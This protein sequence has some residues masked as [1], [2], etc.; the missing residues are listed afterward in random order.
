MKNFLRIALVI[1]V[2]LCVAIA[3]VACTGD[4]TTTTT[5]GKTTT[6]APSTSTAATTTPAATTTAAPT[7]TTAVV[8]TT[9]EVTTTEAPGLFLT[10]SLTIDGKEVT[11]V[12]FFESWGTWG[13]TEDGEITSTLGPA[14]GELVGV[15]FRKG[16]IEVRM[17][18]NEDATTTKTGDSGF[19][20]ALSDPFD[21]D[22][23]YYFEG[24]A[25]Y[26]F[27]LVSD[28]QGF[29]VSRVYY[30]GGAWHW[31]PNSNNQGIVAGPF[32][33]DGKDVTI[34]IDTDGETYIDCYI[35]GTLI[36]E[37]TIPEGENLFTYRGTDNCKVGL[38]AEGVGLVYHEITIVNAD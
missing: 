10:P 30:E 26:Y 32:Y 21:P 38:R 31:M 11:D 37:I 18:M 13:L 25:S 15:E 1:A 3:M 20:F 2:V 6:A 8:T 35:N 22:M 17:T 12:W 36:S 4:D 33:E 19:M 28:S 16:T 27:A 29:G 7:T 23:P 24:G 34:K 14:L 5:A 9:A